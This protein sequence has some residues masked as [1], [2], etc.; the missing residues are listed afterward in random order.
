MLTFIVFRTRV[1]MHLFHTRV[2]GRPIAYKTAT[3]ITMKCTTTIYER[4]A[5]EETSASQMKSASSTHPFREDG[6]VQNANRWTV[7]A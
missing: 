7:S 3:M 6:T 4:L 5:L 2:I 1:A